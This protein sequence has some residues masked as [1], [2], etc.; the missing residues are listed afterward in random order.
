[1]RV[2]LRDAR[3][4]ELPQL[5]DRLYRFYVTDLQRHGGLTQAEAEK[6]ATADHARLLPD[7]RPLEGHHLFM[8]EDEHE[9]TIGHLWY[10]EQGA[11]VF[12]Y[13]IELDE[14]VRGRGYGRES[15]QAFEELARE[16]GVTGVWLNVF[17]G[18]EVAR[19][20]Y[21]SLGYAESSVHMNKRLA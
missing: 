6:K 11:D 17:G 8:I 21:R 13:S 15:M 7:G 9:A 18:N 10:G 19:S 12:L 2:R 4:N 16:R 5:V 3:D 14:G 1:M 20:L